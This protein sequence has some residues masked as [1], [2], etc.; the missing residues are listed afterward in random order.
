MSG[1]DFAAS[2]LPAELTE[3]AARYARRAEVET[4]ITTL[5]LR[6]DVYDTGAA[7]D[8]ADEIDARLGKARAHVLGMVS[9][10]RQGLARALSEG[11]D[12]AA[13]DFEAA[14]AE[15]EAASAALLNRLSSD[16]TRRHARLMARQGSHR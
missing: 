11:D 3:L 4:T 15:L 6:D 16:A 10:A 5:G 9:A 13:A 12:A 1:D 8:A 2:A 7:V 14:I